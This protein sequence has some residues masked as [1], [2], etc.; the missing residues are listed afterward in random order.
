MSPKKTGESCPKR[1]GFHLL[2]FV[3][4]YNKIHMQQLATKK[5]R[6]HATC[7]EF[8]GRWSALLSCP[9]AFPLIPKRNPN[10]HLT[11]PH[12]AFKPF[13][14]NGAGSRARRASSPSHWCPHRP[15]VRTTPWVASFGRSFLAAVRFF[16]VPLLNLL[17]NIARRGEAGSWPSVVR[18]GW[19]QRGS[20]T[21]AAVSVPSAAPFL[22]HP[23]KSLSLRTL[24]L[25][26]GRTH[27]VGL[28]VLLPVA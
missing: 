3:V 2:E 24:V 17:V 11:V 25:G 19:G 21:V 20:A 7:N 27:G 13:G 15:T 22:Y 9:V 28:P 14:L 23:L 5:Q 26:A 18:R 6:I 16:T 12:D 8:T 10:G 4:R 1:G